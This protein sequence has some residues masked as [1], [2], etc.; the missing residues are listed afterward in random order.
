ME[1]NESGMRRLLGSER[2]LPQDEALRYVRYIDDFPVY[3]LNN[4]WADI[5]GAPDRRYIVETT[6]KIVERCVLMT[7]DPSDL[8]LDPTCG[9]GTTAF[10]AEQWGRRWITI[11]TSRI[12]LNIAK[13]RLMTATFPYYNLYDETNGDIRQGFKYKTVPHITLKSLA[14]DEPP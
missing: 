5:G 14:N 8:V 4:V 2:V 6:T 1:T 12:A 10:V 9:S 11:D 13:Q 7:T 3:P